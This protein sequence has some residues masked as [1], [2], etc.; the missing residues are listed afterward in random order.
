M[1][2]RS[3]T[4]L[5]QANEMLLRDQPAERM[6]KLD[7]EDSSLDGQITTEIDLTRRNEQKQ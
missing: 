2:E 1:N 3:K 6:K 5:G 4:P 7:E